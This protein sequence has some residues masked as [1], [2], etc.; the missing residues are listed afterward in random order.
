MQISEWINGG[1]KIAITGP[2]SSG[3]TSLAEKL[4]KHLGFELVPDYSRIYFEKIPINNNEDSIL[5]IARNQIKLERELSAEN[6]SI[7]CD[8]DLINIKIWLSYYDYKL[9]D[10]I[11]QHIQQK[12]YNFSLLLYPNVLWVNDGLRSN[13]FNRLELFNR[14]ESELRH[15][16][17]PYF[18]I[19]E[20]GEERNEQ[21]IEAVEHFLS[22]A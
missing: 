17:I 12:P 18:V 11:D 13:E 1:H 22:K 8:T 16:G 9:P 5:E 20:L 19:N 6:K 7:L 4:S 2:E 21:A 15:Y 14:F 10:F 3:K